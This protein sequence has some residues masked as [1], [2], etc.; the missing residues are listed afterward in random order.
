[1]FFAIFGLDIL[2]E[3][4]TIVDEKR[5]KEIIS[6]VYSLQV[7]R[8]STTNDVTN[9]SD[10]A[11]NQTLSHSSDDQT[12]KLIVQTEKQ[13]EEPLK[14]QAHCRPSGKNGLR[15]ESESKL[16]SHSDGSRSNGHCDTASVRDS[17]GNHNASAFSSSGADI[18]AM[19]GFRSSPGNGAR[20]SA[21]TGIANAASTTTTPEVDGET[22]PA[23]SGVFYG[24]RVDNAFDSSHVTMTY[25]ALAILLILKDDF[26]GVDREAILTGLKV[27]QKIGKQKEQGQSGNSMRLQYRFL[28]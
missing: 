13:T 11:Q 28:A 12:E 26:R 21:A 9:H 8:P 22:T 20:L 3:L 10:T 18:S 25:N 16:S 17:A 15:T 6:W 23:S 2:G 14:E 24:T 7:L 4:E 19:L 1:M 5:R 27:G